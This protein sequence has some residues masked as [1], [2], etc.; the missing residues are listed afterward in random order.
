MPASRTGPGEDRRP[1]VSVVMPTYQDGPHLREALAGV[2][3]QTFA[4]L[5][6][7]VV[8]DGST[9][10]TDDVLA[11]VA[12]PRLRVV[13]Q[14]NQGIVAAL[15][16]GLD[17]ARGEFVARMDGDDLLPPERLERQVAFLRAH[18]HV[19]AC[20]TDYELFG[21]RTGVVR[22]PRTVRQCR[23]R[24]LFG[25]CVAHGTAMIRREVLERAGLRYREEYAYA[26][27]F[28]LFSELARHGELANL[29]LVGL[30]YRVHSAQISTARVEAQRDVTVRLVR[31]N[32][33]RAGV[34]GLSP[35][36]V[37]SWLWPDG[38]GAR[39]AARYLLRGAP[40][41]VTCSARAGGVPALLSALRMVREN[42]NTA[43][44]T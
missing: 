5:E 40:G 2:L 24:I 8:V 28:H 25:T 14:E 32:L 23:G 12:D 15:N 41:L 37:R 27:D 22:M 33:A 1:T 31:E 30:R 36:A 42:L 17:L 3:G 9:D 38:R 6:A 20:G 16:R 35:K 10:E 4:D 39:A 13:R 19:V 44:R 26:E 29:D 21:Q 7:V 18:P 11:S 34:A 43:L